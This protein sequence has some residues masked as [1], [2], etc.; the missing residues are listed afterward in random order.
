MGETDLF[1]R[2]KKLFRKK[3][4]KTIQLDLYEA[5]HQKE[6]LARGPHE[7]DG[8]ILNYRPEDRE[9]ALRK[10]ESI[11]QDFKRTPLKKRPLTDM[12][13]GKRGMHRSKASTSYQKRMW[14]PKAKPE[15]EED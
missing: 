1:E 3:T 14:N 6:L 2:L 5:E 13:L 15:D 7:Y 9:K 4:E 11:I 10:A 8:E 12:N